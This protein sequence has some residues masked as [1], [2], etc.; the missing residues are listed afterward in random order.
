MVRF[1]SGTTALGQPKAHGFSG[2][3]ASTLKEEL[4]QFSAAK[5]LNFFLGGS[6][7][8]VR[9]CWVQKMNK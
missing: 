3:E 9:P 1:P 7:A 6:V 5:H 8:C 2:F 4:Q